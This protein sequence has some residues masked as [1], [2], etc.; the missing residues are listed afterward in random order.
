MWP[1]DLQA[2]WRPTSWN[3]GERQLHWF[4][5]VS[6]SVYWIFVH[7]T[8]FILANKVRDIF[9]HL[10]LLLFHLADAALWGASE[11]RLLFVPIQHVFLV[12]VSWEARPARNPKLSFHLFQ[13]LLEMKQDHERDW[14]ESKDSLNN[15]IFFLI[16]WSL[17]NFLFFMKEEEPVYGP[18]AL[19]LGLCSFKLLNRCFNCD[20]SYLFLTYTWLALTQFSW[21]ALRCSLCFSWSEAVM[22]AAQVLL[23]LMESSTDDKT[24]CS[25]LQTTPLPPSG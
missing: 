14:W 20:Y 2:L 16:N 23:K 18:E 11:S 6:C 19:F 3:T 1:P 7:W 17:L 10:V 24:S 8:R 15:D 5:S 12:L 13:Y 25:L 22:G 4:L 21:A 9:S